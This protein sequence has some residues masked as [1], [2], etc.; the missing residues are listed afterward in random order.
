MTNIYTANR[1][2]QSRPDDQRFLSLDDLAASVQARRDASRAINV[3]L[4][5]LALDNTPDGDMIATSPDGQPIAFTNWSFG[6]LATQLGA[7]PSY[8]RKLPAPLARVNL[9]YA[10]EFGDN[11]ESTKLLYDDRQVRAFTS[12]SYG[13]I[14][15]IQVVQAVQKINQDNRWHVPLKAYDGQNS[16][17]ATTLYASDRDVFV[18][19]VDENR[20]IEIDG[21]AYFR[22]FVTWNSEVGKA[23]F[24]LQT[25]LY[26][27][28]CANRIIWGARDVEE[29]RIRH[30][31]L[32]PDRFV[33][34]AQ[35]ALVAMSESSPQ[36][37]VEAI[38][39][40]KQTR[41]GKTVADVE[42]WLAR[43]G[44]GR[45]EAKLAVALAERGGDTGSS[46]DPTNLWDV[47]QGGTAAA[48]AI[49]HADSRLDVER[50]WSDL[51]RT[52]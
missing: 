7:P 39:K 1:Q 28:V 26:S 9:E 18:F 49:G 30:T 12:T 31:S 19:L 34:Q 25:F 38:H 37:I 44:F 4:D 27:Y 10:L 51:L 33:E 20:S 46:G 13:R 32:A 14:W 50:R 52:N 21:Q 29:L 15:D 22:G 40:A 5:R 23:V 17:Q 43:K 3:R 42:V 2:W 45:A 16:K 36:P 35:P 24:G 8:L 6:Q 47:V 48:R 41:L 11:R